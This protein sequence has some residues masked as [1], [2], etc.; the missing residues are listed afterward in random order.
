LDKEIASITRLCQ[1]VNHNTSLGRDFTIESLKSEGYDAIFLGLGAQASQKLGLDGENMDGVLSGTGFLKDFTLGKEIYIGR[2]VIVSGGGN[3]AIDS[4]RTAL[5]LG[6]EEVTIMYRRS[7]DQMPASPEEVEQAEQEGIRL[8]FLATPVKINSRDGHV[9]NLECIRMA[10]GEPDASGRRRPE[11]I[12]GSEFT[13]E[14]DTLIAAV[15][16]TLDRSSLVKNEQSILSQRS[17]ININADTQET[18]YEGVFAGGDC[19]SGPATVVQA[20]AAGR[21]AAVSINQYLNHQP[22]IPPMKQFNC[23]KGEPDDIDTAEYENTARI[24]RTKMPTMGTEVRRKS[25][26]EIESGFTR[27]M[28]AAEAERCLACGCQ[29]VQ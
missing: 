22:V 3:T 11:P 15:G 8:E 20:I 17:Y 2:R 25:F 28:A 1:Q 29:D 24:P 26:R 19:T 5:R 9:S 27:E 12:T 7:R 4:A 6:A 16:Q 18:P 21:R 23:S 10:L 14:A 13:M